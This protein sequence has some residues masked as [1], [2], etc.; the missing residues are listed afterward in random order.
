MSQ[1]FINKYFSEVWEV[2]DTNIDFSKY[3]P[4]E[5]N[6]SLHVYEEKYKINNEIYRL[7]YA[8]GEHCEPII[9]KL[10]KE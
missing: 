4:F 6:D 3:T 8:I 10:K 1:E 2:V 7:L 5:T 9:E